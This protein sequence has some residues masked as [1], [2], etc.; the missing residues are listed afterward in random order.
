MALTDPPLSQRIVKPETGK[1]PC[2]PPAQDVASASVLSFGPFRLFP[3]QQLLLKHDTPVHMGARAIELLAALAERSG[4]LVSKTELMDRAWPNTVVEESNLKVHMTALRRA[5]GDGQEGQRYIATVVG[6]G[7][8]FVSPVVSGHSP[9]QSPMPPQLAS[10]LPALT[11][12]VVGR[13][14][15]IEAIGHQ[16]KQHRLVTVLGSG[17][18]G[19]TTIALGVATAVARRQD[20]H[21]CFADLGALGDSR[22]VGNAIAAAAGLTP[23]GGDSIP[24]LVE[25]FAQA[26]RGR[27]TLMVLDS[28]E[29][30]IEEVAA[31]ADRMLSAIPE[32]CI[33]ATSR[34]TLRVR[35]ECVYRLQPLELPPPA[36]TLT[37]KQAL[38]YAAVE[39]F[40]RRA[41]ECVDEFRLRDDDAPIVADICRRLDGIAL[42]IELAAT[43]VDAFGIRELQLLLDDRFR[44][45]MQ[46]RR[47]ALP[48]HR[49]LGAALDW[50]YDALPPDEQALLR[51]LSVFVAPFTLESAIALHRQHGAR[52]MPN[53]ACIVDELARLVAKSL[54]VAD[55]GGDAV[56]YRLL[57]TTRAYG[58]RKLQEARELDLWLHHHAQLTMQRL[59]KAESEWD[60]R[61]A[62]E[63]LRDHHDKIDDVRAALKWAFTSRSAD[64][65]DGAMDAATKDMALSLTLAAIP[66]WMHLSL[67][68]ECQQFVR[69]ALRI[70]DAKRESV[71]AMKLT[72]ALAAALLYATGSTPEAGSAWQ[73]TLALAEHNDDAEHRLRA[74]WGLSVY[75]TYRGEHRTALELEARFRALADAAGDASAQ[76]SVDRMMATSLRYLGDQTQAQSHLERMLSAYVAPARGSHIAR[77][78]LDQRAAAYGTLSNVLWLRGYPDRAVDTARNAFTHA[79]MTAHALSISNALVH[80]TCTIA[81]HVGDYAGARQGLTLLREHLALHPIGYWNALSVALDGLLRI[82]LGD[83]SGIA[84]LRESLDALDD[85][86]FRLRFPAF[87]GALAQGLGAEGNLSGAHATIDAAISAAVTSGECWCMAELLRI[88][89]ELWRTESRDAHAETCFL[90][91]I[92]TARESHALSWELRAMTSYSQLLGAHGR[93]AE[94][95]TALDGV[96]S[97]FTEGHGTADL[98]Q[99]AAL[100][101]RLRHDTVG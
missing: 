30:V 92:S 90:R 56:R 43:R 94:A 45:L 65:A 71:V 60:A 22:F 79:Q 76:S 69:R 31:H 52:D 23:Q 99:A 64:G 70:V 1:P 50:S 36:P 75:H 91:S 97:R 46:D 81:L 48:R 5:L 62:D 7:Y 18:I 17:G 54:V 24:A 12:C 13:A 39:L 26:L 93:G 101:E 72:G 41:S 25:A 89:G 98:R 29:L 88:K 3:A 21:V 63:W 8:R 44:I 67:Y 49:T 59:A 6:R 82:A 61:P 9:M 73:R 85:C 11:T 10:R 38:A 96:L 68:D 66:L 40:V 83:R 34:E 28:C 58:Q 84:M 77:F 87:L 57:D 16:L 35:G 100:I 4:E 42:A 32:L 27:P 53:P 86:G 19:K 74:L 95:A 51:S 37:A 2:S 20:T 78:Q 47:G 80:A 14:D 33:L 15:A 55:L